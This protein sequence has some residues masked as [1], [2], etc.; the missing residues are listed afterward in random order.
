MEALCF[1]KFKV[2]IT[3]VY[4]EIQYP[5]ASEEELIDSFEVELSKHE[6]VAMCIIDHVSSMVCS[7]IHRI[8][9]AL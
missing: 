7:H 2:A 6:R 9:T 4:I 8:S 3:V 5:L 1:A